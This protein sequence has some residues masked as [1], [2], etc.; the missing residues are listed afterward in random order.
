MEKRYYTFN[1][2]LRERFGGPVYKIPLTAALGCP[3]RDGAVGVNGCVFCDNRAFSPFVGQDLSITEQIH[4]FKAGRR[5]KGRYIAYLQSY[6][7]TYGPL[8][9]LQRLYEEALADPEVVGL[10]VAT[11]PDCVPDE[12]LNLLESYTDRWMVWIEYGLQSCHDETLKRINRGHDFAAFADAV[13]R[14][15]GRGIYTGAHV[16][17]GLPG[18]SAEKVLETAQALNTLGVDG[19]K[20]HQL[21]IFRGTPLAA[22]WEAGKVRTLE[23]GEYISIAC[24]FIENLSPKVVILR[25]VGDVTDDALLLSPRWGV[26]KAEVIAAIDRE[27]ERRGTRQGSRLSAGSV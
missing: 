16:I 4:R 11:R 1:R 18:E 20:L 12:V 25:L 13:N 27:L 17:I 22:D 5:Q 10:S 8:A 14:T 26:R 19:V 3:N 15:R 24:D 23:V 7:N 2:F 9:Q 21:Q 6:T